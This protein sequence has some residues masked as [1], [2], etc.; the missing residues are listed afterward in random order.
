M[1]VN[2]FGQS[3]CELQTTHLRTDSRA[4][5]NIR[6]NE[7]KKRRALFGNQSVVLLS[8]IFGKRTVVHL[9]PSFFLLR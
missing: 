8:I 1:N 6:L 5:D 9:I 4:A 2:R 7:I 3:V